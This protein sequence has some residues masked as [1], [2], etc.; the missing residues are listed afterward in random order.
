LPKK[1]FTADLHLQPFNSDTVELENGIRLKLQELLN[2]IIQMLE[3]A[4]K[5]NID[6]VVFGGDIGH[7]RSTIHTRPFYLFLDI[8]AQYKDKIRYKFIPGNHDGH[9]QFPGENCVGIFKGFDYIDVF[10]EPTVEGNI[11]YIPDGFDM[12]NDIKNAEPNKILVSHFPLSEAAT[13]SGLKVTTKFSKKDLK[14]FKLVLLGDYHSH[15]TIDHIHYPGSLIPFNKGETGEKGFIVFDDETLETEFVEVTGFRKYVNVEIDESTDKKSLNK[16]IKE[17]K[18][19]NDF[20][21]VRNNM[22][23]I[24]TELKSLIKDIPVIDNFEPEEILRGISSNMDLGEQMK[25]YMEIQGVPKED[26]DKYLNIG[27]GALA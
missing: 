24:P 19:S 18:E 14:K 26:F 21:T 4:V 25:K 16:I 2:S 13:D 6:T 10:L 11:T 3:Y 8:L 27:L 12:L 7:H 5:N 9:P 22:S 23:I 1:I 17:A 20:I 15:Q